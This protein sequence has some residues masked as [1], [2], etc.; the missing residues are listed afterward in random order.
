MFASVRRSSR[1]LRRGRRNANCFNDEKKR[2]NPTRKLIE[3]LRQFGQEH[4]MEKFQAENWMSHSSRDKA[5]KK[6]APM[7]IVFVISPDWTLR[8]NVRAQLREV[9]IMALGMQA[10]D[11]LEE[12]LMRGVVPS[13][14]V[15]DIAELE[16]PKARRML[17]TLAQDVAVLVAGA[18]ANPALSFPGREV[19]CRPVQVQDVVS[20]VV[21][22]LGRS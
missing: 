16:N 11:D 10:T 9:G 14:I 20:R 6:K 13:S 18:S 5:N 7:P 21:A 15:F 3:N 8:T 2:Q 4:K 12:V 17:E 1:I 22:R 19:L